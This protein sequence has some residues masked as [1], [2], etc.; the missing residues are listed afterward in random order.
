MNKIILTIVIFA[1]LIRNAAAE[2]STATIPASI[3]PDQSYLTARIGSTMFAYYKFNY[4]DQLVLIANL[5]YCGEKDMAGKVIDSVPDLPSFYRQQSSELLLKD[6][7]Q[8]EAIKNGYIL[9]SSEDF[10]WVAQES[11]RK[12]QSLF[13]N[14]MKDYQATMHKFLDDR[15]MEPFCQAAY[16]EAEK[17][18]RK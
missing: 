2:P 16:S 17:Y 15:V 5:R 14:Y 10:E 12:G 8:K 6:L 1:A 3:G 18:T 13:F 9:D 11:L 7:V 4:H